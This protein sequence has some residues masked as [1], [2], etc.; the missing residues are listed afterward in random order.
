MV[1]ETAPDV[2]PDS[3]VGDAGINTRIVLLHIVD[4][5]LMMPLNMLGA[6]GWTNDVVI[7]PPEHLRLQLALSVTDRVTL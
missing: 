4:H 5:E 6:V 3:I 1:L 7:L 2:R